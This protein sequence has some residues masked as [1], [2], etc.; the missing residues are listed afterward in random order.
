M[1]ASLLYFILAVFLISTVSAATIKGTVYSFDL[2]KR[3]DSIITVNTNPT[4]TFVSKDG[5]YSFELEPGNYLI[6]AVYYSNNELEAKTIENI[7]LAP[8]FSSKT[9]IF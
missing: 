9:L 3:P 2:E 5:T 6:T 4:Q 8:L 1:R 7:V